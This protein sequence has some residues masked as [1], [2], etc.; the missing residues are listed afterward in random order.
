MHPFF[1]DQRTHYPG[2]PSFPLLFPFLVLVCRFLFF[3]PHLFFFL[4][5]S[6]V[7]VLL[8]PFGGDR[9]REVSR[10]VLC[11]ECVGERG[12]KRKGVEGQKIR[13]RKT[14]KQEEERKEGK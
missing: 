6:C 13:R 3:K 14:K 11:P 7:E 1:D 10:A 5:R 12:R 2:S 4:S 8:L 9:S